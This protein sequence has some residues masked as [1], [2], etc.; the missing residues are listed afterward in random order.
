MS[1]TRLQR[2]HGVTTNL[3]PGN[4]SVSRLCHEPRVGDCHAGY[5]S[6]YMSSGKRSSHN[7]QSKSAVVSVT[8]QAIEVRTYLQATE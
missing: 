2:R 4:G 8:T 6:P 7:A 1:N 5:A 3:N